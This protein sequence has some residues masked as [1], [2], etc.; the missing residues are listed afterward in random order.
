MPASGPLPLWSLPGFCSQSAG[1]GISLPASLLSLLQHLLR[2]A[3]LHDPLTKGAPLGT[4]P[5]PPEVLHGF[6]APLHP[7]G[8]LHECGS[9][10]HSRAGDSVGSQPYLIEQSR[11]KGVLST[12]EGLG[13]LVEGPLPFSEGCRHGCCLSVLDLPQ[14]SCMTG[15]GLDLSLPVI[16]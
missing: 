14:W 3:F 10:R 15:S 12:R 1:Q 8:Q 5:Q 7:Q 11:P 2:E 13:S 4:F 9:L 16:D 6:W